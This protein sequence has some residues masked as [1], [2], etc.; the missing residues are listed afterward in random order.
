MSGP[1]GGVSGPPEAEAGA[2]AESGVTLLLPGQLS[3]LAGGT[4]RVR[5][6]GRSATVRAALTALRDLHPGV[7]ARLVTER[8]E[9]RPHINVF[10]GLEEVRR[11]DG[12]D[13]PLETGAE[14]VVLP[15]VS[16]G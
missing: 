16:G 4:T 6:K 7:H 2:R 13:T 8:G 1:Q 12:L 14:I 10:V 9:L 11:L 5:L 15:S 3:D